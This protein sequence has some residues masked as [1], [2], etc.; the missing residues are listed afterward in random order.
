MNGKM[1]IAASIVAVALMFVPGISSALSAQQN[2]FTAHSD[3]QG[4][5]LQVPAGNATD[6]FGYALLQ[7][8]NQNKQSENL[9]A[10]NST[11]AKSIFNSFIAQSSEGQNLLKI[12][13]SS[14]LSNF[15]KVD[16]KS[17]EAFLRAL[18]NG[19]APNNSTSVQSNGVT[20]NY[21]IKL[22]S[23][24]LPSG[25]PTDDGAYGMVQVNYF[26][27]TAPWWL[28]G[29][30]VTYG[31]NDVINALYAGND[32]QNFYN[33]A[34]S[35]SNDGAL[36]DGFALGVISVGL[37]L[38]PVT[39][40]LSALA[41]GIIAGAIA[42][43][44]FAVTVFT[45]NFQSAMTNLYET[46]WADQPS[47]QKFIW[48]YT[49]VNY[50]YPSVTVVGVLASNVGIYGYEVSGNSLASITVIPWYDLS[51]PTY[52]AELSSDTQTAGS[53]HGW[54]VWYSDGDSN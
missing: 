11:T 31:E 37:V 15:H 49:N 20:T 22:S 46:S 35:G 30:S 5:S 9:P 18:E 43:A 24:S 4:M 26:I 32:G 41:A 47:G 39:A 53:S 17:A 45:M 48:I 52:A 33:S 3:V 19:S 36:L 13:T 1:V 34:I 51:S 38:S 10:L 8:Y 21:V 40:G 6:A 7:W 44:G 28:G 23:V 29:W 14:E 27:Y 50:Y 54:N 25:I 42:A 12:I 16:K 2:I